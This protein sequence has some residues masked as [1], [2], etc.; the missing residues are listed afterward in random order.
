MELLLADKNKF[1]FV[2]LQGL[3]GLPIEVFTGV[4]LGGPI[5][6]PFERY[7][8]TQV[9]REMLYSII[10]L[11]GRVQFS[12]EQNATLD[13]IFPSNLSVTRQQQET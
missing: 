4:Y 5:R 7:F 10:E 6:S 3:G 1:S 8:S 9:A 13:H 11:V 12:S 2:E